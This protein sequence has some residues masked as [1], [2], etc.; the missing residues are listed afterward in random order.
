LENLETFFGQ[1]DPLFRYAIEFRNLSWLKDETWDLLKKF[2]VTYT[3]VD[4]PL[5]PAEMHLTADFAYF[6]WHG[7]GEKIWFDY[8]YST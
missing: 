6:R 1:L 8:R 4:E 2:N 7:K 5:L 3:I